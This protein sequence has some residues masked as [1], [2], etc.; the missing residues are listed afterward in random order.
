MK[1]QKSKAILLLIDGNNLIHRAYHAFPKNFSSQKTG[2]Q[3]NAVYGFSRVLLTIIREFKPSFVACVFDPPGKTFRDEKYADYKATRPKADQALYDQI[4]RVKEVVR[5]LGIPIFEEKGFEADDALATIVSKLKKEL[6]RRLDKILI[7]T[8]DQDS[9][10]L[11]NRR[12]SIVSPLVGRDSNLEVTI[13]VVKERLGLEPGQVVDYK[14]LRGDPS[15]N[16]PGVPG[17]GSKTAAQ[18]IGHFG[19]LE[20]LYLALESGRVDA[21]PRIVGL[22]KDHKAEAFFSKE[23]IEFEKDV[24]FSVSLEEFQLG[25]YDLEKAESLFKELGFKSLEKLLPRVLPKAEQTRLSL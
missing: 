23:L 8:N 2:E 1:S 21:K 19:S 24:P 3:T 7:A 12:V 6:G 10:Q 22:L 4:P 25:R 17:I 14:A 5:S 9:W 15:D 13:E 16:I 11:I 18:L 20:G